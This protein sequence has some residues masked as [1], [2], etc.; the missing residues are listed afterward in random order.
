MCRRNAFLVNLYKSS[1]Y[2]KNLDSNSMRLSVTWPVHAGAFSGTLT[3][4][5]CP[6]VEG[7]IG[8][9][10][11]TTHVLDTARG[12]PA[13]GLSVSLYRLEGETR[14]LISEVETNEDG[15]ASGPLLEG[16][17][18]VVGTYELLFQAG[19]YFDGLGSQLPDPKFLDE[20]PIRFGIASKDENYHV[21]LLISPFGFSTYR[22]S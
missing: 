1:D 14:T 21:P 4:T 8:M 5:T 15:R 18:M 2:Q 20:V 12:C 9:G 16:D 3:E 17:S 22:G 6:R 19:G 7:T 10:K 13:K 11:L